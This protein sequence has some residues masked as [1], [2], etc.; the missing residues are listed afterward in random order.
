MNSSTQNTK[1][2]ESPKPSTVESE[3]VEARA[4]RLAGELMVKEVLEGF[5]QLAK[6]K[7]AEK[8]PHQAA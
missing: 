2:A 7:A 6:Q 8:K 5:R 3:D 4:N 1:L